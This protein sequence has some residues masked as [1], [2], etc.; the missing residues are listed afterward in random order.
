MQASD[1]PPFLLQLQLEANKDQGLPR[2]DFRLNNHIVLVL[3]S[4]G[5]R[6]IDALGAFT[7]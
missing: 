5:S 2:Y 4:L 1:I 3:E 6:W 7:C